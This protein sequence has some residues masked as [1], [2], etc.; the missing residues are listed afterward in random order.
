MA[1]KNVMRR[2]ANFSD[3]E[4]KSMLLEV[5]KRRKIVMGKFDSAVTTRAKDLAWEGMQINLPP[6]QCVC[7]GSVRSQTS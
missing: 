4:I 1:E 5:T 2:K 7:V 6:G 3:I